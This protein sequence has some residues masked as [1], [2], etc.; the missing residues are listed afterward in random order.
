MSASLRLWD[1]EG[2]CLAWRPIAEYHCDAA[3]IL[4]SMWEDNGLLFAPNNQDIERLARKLLARH[5]ALQWRW[6]LLREYQEW[7]EAN[8]L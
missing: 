1:P 7:T 3:S 2:R 4:R 6:W 8:P 5:R